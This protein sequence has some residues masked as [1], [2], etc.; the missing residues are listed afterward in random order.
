M[1]HGGITAPSDD[2][3]LLLTT[4]CDYVIAAWRETSLR[5]IPYSGTS[6]IRARSLLS[7]SGY[8]TTARDGTNDHFKIVAN[9]KAV[10]SA[11]TY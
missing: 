1:D 7:S 3:Y 10:W 11:H 4:L 5:E 2:D 6:A 8:D 9:F